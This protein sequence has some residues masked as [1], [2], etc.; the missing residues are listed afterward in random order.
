MADSGKFTDKRI[1]LLDKAPKNS[2]DR[3]WCFWE[4][5]SGYFEEIVH[6]SWDQ[7]IF[8]NEKEII[9][10]DISP[11]R[12]KMIRGIDFYE[13]ALSK[14]KSLEI[15]FKFGEISIG[16][17]AGE[18]RVL[19]NAEELI[20][21]N[22]IVFNSIYQPVTNSMHFHLLQHFKGWIIETTFPA[23]DPGKGTLMD[24]SVSQQFGT[25]FVYVLPLS[26]TK[27]LVEYTL[28]TESLLQPEAYQQALNEYVNNTLKLKDYKI[29]EE[30][31]G[32]IPMTNTPFPFFKDGIYNIGTAG[33]QTKASTGYTFQFIQK[34][35]SKILNDLIQNGK[36]ANHYRQSFRFDFY[37]STFLHIL[38]NNKVPGREVFSKLFRNNKASEV[39]KFLDNETSVKKEL[40]II[41]S[42]PTWPFLVAGLK[43]VG[44]K[45]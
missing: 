34:Q 45:I 9:E 21:G 29:L 18:K 42:L 10:L 26:S 7:L 37:D 19:F 32:V 41:S 20:T 33:G 44:K 3:T 35:S 5:Q 31:F 1:L 30:E 16:G 8:K 24:F 43:E 6:H 15:D 2:N 38:A 17:S 27:A 12:Y 11:Y 4:K 25:T 36:P 40:K 22:A 23:F 39:F 28:F 13:Y 14:I